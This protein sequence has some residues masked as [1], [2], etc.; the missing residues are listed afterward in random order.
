MIMSA[1]FLDVGRR[2]L[3][4]VTDEN[5][6]VVYSHYHFA[7][8]TQSLLFLEKEQRSIFNGK[9]GKENRFTGWTGQN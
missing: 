8:V 5:D 7:F 4:F 9:N 6:Q 3:R 2:S 1:S